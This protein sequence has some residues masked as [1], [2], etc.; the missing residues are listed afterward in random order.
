[1]TGRSRPVP[2]KGS[3][4]AKRDYYDVLGSK[5]GASAEELKK[6]YRQKAKELHPDRNSDNPEAETQFKEVNEAYE[7]LGTPE[8]R[9]KYDELGANWRQYEQA[10]PGAGGPFGGAGQGNYRTM[11]PEEMEAMFGE[12]GS[13]F[14]DFFNTF[15]GG[16][17][18]GGARAR[19]GRGRPRRA[20][21]VEYEVAR[22]Y[23]RG[24]DVERQPADGEG[25]GR[26]PARP[27]PAPARA[28]PAGAG[29]CGR[30]RGFVRAHRVACAHGA[31]RR[32]E[33]PLRSTE[34][35]GIEIA[36]ALAGMGSARRAGRLV[37]E[38]GRS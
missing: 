11:T 35:V 16:Q 37:R 27:A 6:A 26:H 9:K 4:V 15:F 21:D 36:E 34:G 12:G 33:S 38:D 20:P 24:A 3:A 17:A 28:R 1:M 32:G 29:R 23:G 25:A 19:G 10:P 2:G 7:V 14:S 22:R 5:R 30:S 31:L 8:T 18:A 13:P